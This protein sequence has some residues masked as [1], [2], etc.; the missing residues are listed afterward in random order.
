MYRKSNIQEL[1]YAVDSD[2]RMAAGKG[3][4]SIPRPTSM[5]SSITVEMVI[6]AARLQ[7]EYQL[8]NASN[9]KP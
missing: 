9:K 3:E 1:Y 5:S 4:K 7:V 8:V 6:K 2:L